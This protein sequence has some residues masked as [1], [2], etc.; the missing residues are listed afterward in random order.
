MAKEKDPSTA[1]RYF[2]LGVKASIFFDPSSRLKVTRNTPGVLTRLPNALVV[3]AMSK[4]AIIEIKE[5]E[6]KEMMS[7]KAVAVAASDKASAEKAALRARAKKGSK[8]EVTDAEDEDEEEEKELPKVKP[9]AKTK[10]ADKKKEEDDDD[11]E[12]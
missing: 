4:G 8:A 10:P 3:E 2:K 1:P 9:A 11:D 5:S 6:Y 12:E 7:N